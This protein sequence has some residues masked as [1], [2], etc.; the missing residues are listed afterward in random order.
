MSD[1]PDSHEKSI[2]QVDALGVLVHELNSLLD[3]SMRCLALAQQALG[4]SPEISARTVETQRQ[5]ETVHRA[6]DRMAELVHSAMCGAAKS[7]GSTA[8][9]T[10]RAVSVSEAVHHAAEVCRPLASERGVQ[11]SVQVG[12]GLDMIAAGPMYALVLNAMRNAVESVGRTRRGG[13]VSI[14]ASAVPTGA[15]ALLEIEIRDDGEG[16]PVGVEPARLFRA[17]VSTKPGG[18]GI[19]LSIAAQIGAS[20]GGSVELL[21]VGIQGAPRGATFRLRCPMPEALGAPA[22]SGGG[23]G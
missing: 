12:L 14:L 22:R 6:M 13:R 3:G 11:L 9:G 4:G 8:M 5:L 10:T 2:T 1:T 21:P 17:G 19:G 15:G 18:S 23:E 16:L 7:I 20:M